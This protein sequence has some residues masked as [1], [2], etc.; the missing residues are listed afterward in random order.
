MVAAAPPGTRL[1]HRVGL[2]IALAV[3]VISALLPVLWV[4]KMSLVEPR[5][6]TKTPPT[7]WPHTFT[8]S[9]YQ[10]IF[11][12]PLFLRALLNSVIIAGI[13]TAIALLLG[14]LAAYPLS[15]LRFRFRT[16]I[17]AGILAISFFPMVA[18]IAPLFVE[19]R[20]LGLLDSYAGVIIVDTV[21][22]LPLTVWILAAFFRQLPRE[23]EDAAKVDG[24]T[25]LQAFRKI[26]VPLAAPG[27]FT[28]AILTFITTWNE[29]L[30]ANTFLLDNHKW[31]VTVLIPNFV[32]NQF[33]PDYA[34][35]AAAALVVTVPIALLVLVFQRRIVSGLTAGALIG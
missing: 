26:I 1:R 23:L 16:T 31:P 6:L 34:A 10:K 13:T 27:V 14:S 35:Q 11:S 8:L 7:I 21:F 33:T 17:M 29:Y 25:T 24:A 19:F 22:V 12:D 9:H 18:I 2:Y 32:A 15:R 30:F 5:E 20:D 3:I 4:L 28:A